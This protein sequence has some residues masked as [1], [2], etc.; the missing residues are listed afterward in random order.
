MF[1]VLFVICVFFLTHIGTRKYANVKI[2][3]LLQFVLAIYLS[4]TISLGAQ[5][6]VDHFH[7][8]DNYLF[9]DGLSI[10]DIGFS[11]VRRYA[12]DQE[13][14]EFGYEIFSIICHKLNIGFPGFMF[15][16]MVFV[17][18]V[19]VD[20]IFKNKYPLLSILFFVLSSVF[21]QEANLVRQS[22]AIALFVFSFRYIEQFNYKRYVFVIACATLFHVSA[23]FLL[24][25]V[26]LGYTKVKSY[27][28][29]IYKI[30]ITFW[31]LS[32]IIAV[33]DINISLDFLAN[34]NNSQFSAYS[35]HYANNENAIG[36]K[37][38]FDLIVNTFAFFLI[39]NLNKEYSTTNILVILGI[40]LLNISVSVPNIARIAL[41][42]TSIIPVY[43]TSIIGKK[44]TP[45]I[46]NIFLFI[47][48]INNIRLLFFNHILNNEPDLGD[49][50]Y[51]L[52]SFFE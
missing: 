16:L 11:L 30:I 34:M 44:N 46:Y 13:G 25:F 50:M 19:Y 24:P 52:S 12:I 35:S 2:N 43:Y 40:V 1:W 42:F 17:N 29:I 8:L 6:A 37:P 39:I 20:I 15:I 18:W 10:S 45:K 27:H 23:L 32:V 31:I 47:L 22:V 41:Y 14:Y 26:L 49:I 21:F 38:V 36:M 3:H 48:V 9:S 7:Y 5:F 4:L 33:L 28:S 51:P